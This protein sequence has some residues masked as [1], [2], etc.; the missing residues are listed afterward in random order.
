MALKRGGAPATGVSAM[1]ILPVVMLTG[2]CEGGGR[3]ESRGEIR[4]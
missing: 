3:G 2:A 1:V 4:A